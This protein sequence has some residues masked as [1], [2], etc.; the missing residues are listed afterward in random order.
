[1][2]SEPPSDAGHT[3]G[4]APVPDSDAT[5]RTRDGKQGWRSMAIVMGIVVVV[6]AF[7][8]ALY[9]TAGSDSKSEELAPERGVACVHLLDAAHAYDDGDQAA[10]DDAIKRGAR[11][12]EDTLQ[13]SGQLFGEPERIAL[14]LDLASNKDA[15][16]VER[17][18]ELALRDC[19]GLGTQ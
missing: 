5:L 16:H 19:Q 15:A 17:L 9:V 8:W 11:V 18:L 13:R 12:A 2:N 14:E 6:A 3:N 7:G 4:E 10:F 1:M